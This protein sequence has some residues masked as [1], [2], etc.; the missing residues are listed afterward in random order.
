MSSSTR[1]LTSSERAALARLASPRTQLGSELLATAV[2]FALVFMVAVWVTRFVA[3]PPRGTTLAWLAAGAALPALAVLVM[4]HLGVTPAFAA[5]RAKHAE[6]LRLGLATRTTYEVRDALKVTE[7]EDE[8]SSYYL[9][10][11]GGGVLFLSGQ[12]LYEFEAG[13]DENGQPTPARFPCRRFALERAAASGLFLA[14]EPLGPPFE[15]SGTLPSFSDADH[16]AGGVPSDG[17][18][19]AVDFESLRTRRAS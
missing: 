16:H 11:A 10:L 17:D 9:A 6:D 1:P 3:G 15:P 8:G 14:L 7:F 18:R 2:V 13:E 4:V 5:E 19:L 12:Y